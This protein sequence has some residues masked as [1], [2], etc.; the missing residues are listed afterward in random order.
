MK[1]ILQRRMLMNGALTGTLSVEHRNEYGRLSGIEKIC[2]TM[3]RK[4]GQLPTGEYRVV[5]GKCSRFAR[6][7]L[8]LEPIRDD[9]SSSSSLP[10][11]ETCKRC[12]MERKSH[13]FGCLE[14]L[15]AL[16]CPMMQPGNGPFR[17]RQGGILVGEAHA[18]GFVLKSQERFLQLF[19]RIKKVIARKGEV[20]V[21][22]G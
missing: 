9:S 16:P 15:Y 6:Q 21:E 20:V 22:V 10:L 12:R 18:P 1:L 13:E 14:E 4:N 11:P 5:I 8:F 19:D 17:L 2:D 3:E 7:M